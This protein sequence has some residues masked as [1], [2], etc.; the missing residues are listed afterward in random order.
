MSETT[1]TS[2]LI[3]ALAAVATR[4]ISGLAD[5]GKMSTFEIAGFLKDYSAIKEGVTGSSDI[6]KELS[7]LTP[8]EAQEIRS[9]VISELTKLGVSG[10]IQEVTDI[11]LDLMY[12]SAVSVS[13]IRH[14][15]K[16]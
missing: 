14:L 11:V 5:D 3:T 1:E 12:Q 8:E 2:Q 9:Q 16:K 7:D 13:R 4:F 10:S 6:P 15:L